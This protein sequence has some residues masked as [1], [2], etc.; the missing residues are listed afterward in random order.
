MYVDTSNSLIMTI[1]FYIFLLSF[2][3]FCS[4]TRRGTTN[5]NTLSVET[6]LSMFIVFYIFC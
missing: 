2:Y 3:K 1:I 5:I 6:L 4:K